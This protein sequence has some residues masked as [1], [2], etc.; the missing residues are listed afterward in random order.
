MT[1]LQAKLLEMF[2]WLTNFLKNEN[3]RYYVI[4]GTMLGAV[5]HKGFIPW[6]DDIDIGMPRSDYEKLLIKMRQPVDHY[7]VESP[8]DTNKDFPYGY[9]KF[10]DLNT[11]LVEDARKK[12][13]RGI[14]IDIF[15]LD[16][17]GD[18]LESSI[19][20]YKAID[21]TNML[22]AMRV[23]RIRKNRKWWKNLSVILGRIIP[24]N[25]KKLTQKLD[26]LCSKRDFDESIYVGN[27]MS[28]YRSR[29]IMKKEIYGVP[30]LYEFEGLKVY[31]PERFEEYLRILFHNWR[32]L[33]PESKRN[34][35]HN[36]MQIDFEH[37]FKNFEKP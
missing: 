2:S 6:D 19:N 5:R 8:K 13:V 1:N 21:R 29:E 36:F 9:A 11:T 7:Y 31:G 33:P 12:V 14:F 35:S 20:N 26:E 37:S 27:L 16:G 32:E 4:S 28:T 17:I 3:L 22:L 18:N 10:Y 24:F 25:V 30:T 34:T 15:P 23:C